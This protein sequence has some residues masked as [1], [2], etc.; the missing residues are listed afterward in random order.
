MMLVS[1][2]DNNVK[3]SKKNNKY[4]WLAL[5]GS[6]FLLLFQFLLP[7]SGDN[8]VYQSMASELHRY[9]WL[10]Y[11]QSWDQNFPGIVYIHWL[12]IIIFG[13]SIEGFRIFDVLF[14]LTVSWGLYKV[15]IRWI[16]PSFAA[17][18]SILYNLQYLMG[19][20]N[21]SG[22]RDIFAAGLL[23]FATL[24]LVGSEDKNYPVISA[25]V[26]GLMI[27]FITLIRITYIPLIAVGAWYL[28]GERN[29]RSRKLLAFLS[30]IAILLIAVILPYVLRPSGLEQ[31]YRSTIQ[32]NAEIWGKQRYSWSLLF[33]NLRA[34]KIN[35]FAALIG[36]FVSTYSPSSFRRLDTLRNRFHAVDRRDR[37]LFLSY[38]LVGV[39]SVLAMGKYWGYHFALPFLMVLPFAALGM[40]FIFALFRTPLLKTIAVVVFLLYIALRVFPTYIVTPIITEIKRGEVHPITAAWSRSKDPELHPILCDTVAAYVERNTPP[41]GRFECASGLAGVR[42]RVHRRSASRFTTFYSLILRTPSGGHPQFQQEW[43]REYIDSLLSAKPTC[44]VLS[45]HTIDLSGSPAVSIHTLPGFDSLVMPQYRY[46][47]TIGYYM[48]FKRRT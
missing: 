28:W 20:L 15:L 44:L 38:T 41:D 35:I 16:P 10:P 7:L 22:E 9:G 5:A 6:S 30:G 43:R 27:G 1:A 40:G 12:S 8:E 36:L 32:Y 26:A 17:L 31:L 24:L 46:D 47:T 25:V 39:V 2:T 33:D 23:V 45:T 19:A 11:L 4:L 14:H 18:A 13:D 21:V 42:W 48:I 29:L 3:V 37:I 34:E